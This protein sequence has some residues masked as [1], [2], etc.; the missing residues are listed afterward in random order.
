M[1]NF[2]HPLLVKKIR[3][4]TLQDDV[5]KFIND[6]DSFRDVQSI[7]HSHSTLHKFSITSQQTEHQSV[8][9]FG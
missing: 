6:K 9:K 4:T 5:N 1:G 3:K 7:L 8:E 2:V